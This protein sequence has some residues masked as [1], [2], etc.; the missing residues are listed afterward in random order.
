MD[1]ASKIL[2][3]QD[4]DGML[5][6]SLERI[7][8][9]YTDKSHFI[10]ELL[11]NAE[12]AGASCIRFVQY[13][14]KLKVMHD[15]HPFTIENL[16]GLCDI[17]QSDKVNDLNQIGEFGVGFKSVFGI[18][19][20]V[21]LYS[22]PSEEDLA[23]NCQPFAVEIQ[24]FT[25]PVDIPMEEIPEKYTTM[26][27]FPYSVG[28][29]FSGF[30]DKEALNAAV[31]KR[32]KNLG[33]SAL[34]FMKNL[35]L[36]EYEILN[37]GEKAAGQYMLDEKQINDHCT[38]ISAI[39][40]EG[41]KS[42]HKVSF[43][44][45]SMPVVGG[46]SNR[47]IDIAF[48]QEQDEDGRMVFRKARDPYISVYFP[49]ETESKLDFIVQGPFRTTPNRSSVPADDEENIALAEQ[50]V[51]L[52]RR[53]ILELRD[54]G[55][56]DLSFIKILPLDPDVFWTYSLFSP[57]Y[58]GVKKLFDFEKVLPTN[59]GDQYIDSFHALIARSKELTDLLPS[60][61][62]TALHKGK[63]YD[64]LPVSLT[65]TG[66]YKDILAYFS[67]TLGIEVIRP[68]DL[69]SLFNDNPSFIMKCDN[70]WLVRLYKMYETVPNIFSETNYRN[71]LDAVI[72]R[73]ASN[74]VVAPYRKVDGT[75][76]PNVFLPKKGINVEGVEIVHPYLYERCKS[77]FEKVL[78]LKHPDEYE[79]FI[80]MLKK[81]YGPDDITVDPEVYIQ[82][83]KKVVKFL[84]I[85]EYKSDMQNAMATDFVLRCKQ[86]KEIIWVMPDGGQ[87]LFP[88]SETGLKLDW[89]Y[90][91]IEDDRYYLDYDF[92]QSAGITFSDLRLFGVSDNILTDDETVWGEYY[93]GRHGRQP[94]WRTWGEFRWKL[95][96]DQIEDVLLYIESHPT[97]K[98]SMIKS[99]IIFK[100]LQENEDKLF[101]DVHIGSAKYEDK[102]DEPAEILKILNR[103]EYNYK[104]SEWSGKWVYTESNQ[105]VAPSAITKRELNKAI[106][107]NIKLDS[108]LYTYLG[109]KKDKIDQMEAVVK[110]YD[111]IPEEKKKLFFDVEFQR[112]Y[113]MTPD[114]LNLSSDK[115][116]AGIG[117]GNSTESIQLAEDDEFEFPSGPVKN[118]DALKKHAAQILS[119]ANPVRYGRVV[120]SI[121]ISRPQDDI[122]AYLMNMY[123]VGNSYRYACQLCHEPVSNVEMCQ[124]ERKPELEL[125]P[126]N[127]CLCPSCARDFKIFRNNEEYANKLIG[128]I[129]E[130][131]E[132]DISETDPVSIIVHGMDFW[133][134]Q[135][136]LAEIVELLTLR[137]KADL[138]RKKSS[139]HNGETMQLL[140]QKEEVESTKAVPGEENGQ[141]DSEE[142]LQSDMAVYLEYLG[143]RVYHRTQKAYALVKSC[144]GKYITLA[145]E[146]GPKAGDT[147]NYDMAMCIDN[148]WLEIVD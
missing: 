100:L 146:D 129:M 82:D 34:L 9:L 144:D 98:D 57:L 59:A 35:S 132:Q 90:K 112:R 24:D 12:D 10:Y 103:L 64:W 15:G 126:L 50:M 125:E 115:V 70:E 92:Y 20:T 101:G 7:I 62:I 77:F 38:E 27:V 104:L 111:E 68:E 44:K 81:K 89:Y 18:C 31:S 148:D 60:Q 5:R 3:R 124:L 75:Y 135:T 66:P 84:Q 22:R 65:E 130:Y 95:S 139:F 30:K 43:L 85:P 39:E 133:F 134:A 61:L 117:A 58:D 105:L 32:L 52:L 67:N 78:H 96:I 42:E 128:K 2:E 83:F 142:E 69:R 56:L 114:Q 88:E 123:R 8:Q 116:N 63:F 29:Q 122:R 99:Q 127:L 79:F 37:R 107:G 109:F 120:R 141:D 71:I 136:H 47:T 140:S 131:T 23:D 40:V 113:G 36:I 33:I 119:Y 49:T 93:T 87:I 6:R 102:E 108:N 110:E 106:Y 21:R 45:F 51:E 17:G 86:G 137:R 4:R 73:T 147:I 74:N 26:F 16:Q 145:F 48:Q 28:Y 46:L 1:I 54:M 94:E 19:E 55:R 143:K 91:N 41:K 13:D 14:R 53:S 138:E 11:Q 80:K 25:K 72:I 118:W 121:R 76:I 97:L